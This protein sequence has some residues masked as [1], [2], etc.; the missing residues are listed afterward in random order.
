MKPRNSLAPALFTALVVISGTASAQ[1]WKIIDLGTLGGTYSYAYGINDQRQIVGDALNTDGVRHAYFLS[2]GTRSDL[3]IPALSQS[4]ANAINASGQIAGNYGPNGFFYDNGTLT[5]LGTLGGTRETEGR[6]INDSGQVAGASDDGTN[7]HA[8]VWNNG[9]MTDLGTLGGA[10][11]YATGINNAG[12]VTGVAQNSSGIGRAF[13]YANGSMSDIGTL[14]GTTGAGRAINDSGAIVGYAGLASGDEHAFLYENGVMTDIGTLGGTY[15][16]ASAIND[17]GQ[18]VGL[19][20][21]NTDIAHAFLYSK[22]G[23]LI[24]LNSLIDPASNWVLAEG[25]GINERGEIVGYGFHNGLLRGFL[26][27][28]V[29]PIPSTAW[30]F[31]SGLLGMAVAA[32]RR[33]RS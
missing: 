13:L 29:V 20:Y 33:N 26:L 19:S 27:T 28:S 16:Q 9:T 30:L 1:D 23:G 11:S 7:Y 18:V 10:T 22:E 15:S 14:G 24:D 2:H 4:S 5:P 32:R 12:H 3:G 21:L 17:K 31:G 8:F 25:M 6:A